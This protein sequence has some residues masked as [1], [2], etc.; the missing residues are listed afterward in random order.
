[1]SRKQRKT[2]KQQINER[3]DDITRY[4]VKR[5]DLKAYGSADRFITS[6]NTRKCYQR[7][8]TKFCD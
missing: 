5:Q 6:V 7:E 1:M 4:G 3:F 2:V 8:I